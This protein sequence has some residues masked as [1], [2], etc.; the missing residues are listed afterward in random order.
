MSGWNSW[1]KLKCPY[2]IGKGYRI[3]ASNEKRKRIRKGA[4]NGSRGLLVR[5]GAF[6]IYFNIVYYILGEK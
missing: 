4:G 1:Q 5:S 2:L 6:S 3:N